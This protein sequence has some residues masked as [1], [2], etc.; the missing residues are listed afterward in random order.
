MLR[1]LHELCVFHDLCV[2]VHEL[3]SVASII[4]L[5]KCCGPQLVELG[6]V[7]KSCLSCAFAHGCLKNSWWS[8]QHNITDKRV[9]VEMPGK[10]QISIWHYIDIDGLLYIGMYFVNRFLVFFCFFL[11]PSSLP[12]SFIKATVSTVWPPP[13]WLIKSLRNQTNKGIFAFSMTKEII[14][15]AKHFG[16]GSK[17]GC[18]VAPLVLPHFQVLRQWTRACLVPATSTLCE[19]DVWLWP[20]SGGHSHWF[21]NKNYQ[22]ISL[23]LSLWLSGSLSLSLALCSTLSCSLASALWAKENSM[24]CAM[25]RLCILICSDIVWF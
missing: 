20:L 15:E 13:V 8:W 9:N 2:C 18:K 17:F 25:S 24:R 7:K 3:S 5:S 6:W 19:Y 21:G 22:P 1:K 11:M 16:N 12:E 23:W 4:M 14:K 10:V